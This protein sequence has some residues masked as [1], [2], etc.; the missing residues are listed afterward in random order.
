LSPNL[1]EGK[2]RLLRKKNPRYSPPPV[3]GF[4]STFQYFKLFEN[5]ARCGGGDGGQFKL[6]LTGNL[7][8]PTNSK[9]IKLN[10]ITEFNSNMLLFAVAVAEKI[11]RK[12]FYL[13]KFHGAMWHVETF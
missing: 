3:N 4:P 7:L 2:L 1:A 13:N 5:S 11:A 9:L 8:N 6:T 12:N 10:Y